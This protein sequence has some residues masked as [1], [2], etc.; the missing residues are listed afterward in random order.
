MSEENVYIMCVSSPTFHA[1]DFAEIKSMNV[2]GKSCQVNLMLVYTALIKPSHACT[3]DYSF[4][5]WQIIQNIIEWQK[6]NFSLNL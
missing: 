5:K 4:Q 3:A 2:R 6:L 1:T